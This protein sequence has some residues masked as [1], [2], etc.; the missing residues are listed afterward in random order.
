MSVTGPYMSLRWSLDHSVLTPTPPTVHINSYVYFIAYGTPQGS[1]LRCTLFISVG[2]LNLK[3][4]NGPFPIFPTYASSS[5]DTTS[6]F[7]FYVAEGFNK[8]NDIKAVGVRKS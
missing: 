7:F 8:L 5:V 6:F 1:I 4:I 3:L 2:K